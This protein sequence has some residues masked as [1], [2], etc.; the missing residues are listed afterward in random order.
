M[1]ERFG[2]ESQ[3]KVH[4]VVCVTT[5]KNVLAEERACGPWQ[6]VRR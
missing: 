1:L 6:G 2:L 5:D 3:A 4:L